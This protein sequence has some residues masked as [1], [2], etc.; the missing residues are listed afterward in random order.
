MM[1]RLSEA[2]LTMIQATAE[3]T[4][5]LPWDYYHQGQCCDGQCIVNLKNETIVH[6]GMIDSDCIEF[7]VTA[8][9]DILNLIKEVRVL[10]LGLRLAIEVQEA[11]VM[12]TPEDERVRLAVVA[13]LKK[14]LNGYIDSEYLG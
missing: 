3:R 9:A 1:R 10:K 12:D 11:L 5:S 4:P 14:S 13:Q 8:K 2:D 7:L 6:S